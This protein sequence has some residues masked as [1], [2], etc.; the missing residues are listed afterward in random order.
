MRMGFL[1][2]ASRESVVRC[3]SMWSI[4][5]ITVARLGAE[6]REKKV[7]VSLKTYMSAKP[8]VGV[9]L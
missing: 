1:Y 4:A 5:G 8:N 7:V 6:L 2:F 9:S 3:K